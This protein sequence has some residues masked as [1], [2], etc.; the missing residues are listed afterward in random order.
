MGWQAA[1]AGTD[2]GLSCGVYQ[3]KLDAVGSEIQ[4][5]PT[6]GIGSGTIR[7]A[8]ASGEGCRQRGDRQIDGDR[9]IQ[10]CARP[11]HDE[12]WGSTIWPAQHGCVVALWPWERITGLARFYRIQ[13]GIEG[14]E[15]WSIELG[16]WISAD[17]Q[18]RGSVPVQRR[19]GA[20][21]R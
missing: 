13:F 4:I 21:P 19:A 2:Q 14:T 3:S 9:R 15:R 5:R 7:T 18:P 12:H 20:V 16:L 8:A 1:T 10:S 11:D 6:R 17:G